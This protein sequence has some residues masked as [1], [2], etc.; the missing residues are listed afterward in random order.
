MGEVLPQTAIYRAYYLDHDGKIGCAV[1]IDAYDDKAAIEIVE[2]LGSNFGIELWD[3]AR[4]VR[5]FAPK[6]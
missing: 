1:I 2:E 3:R 5:R 4:L 6:Q